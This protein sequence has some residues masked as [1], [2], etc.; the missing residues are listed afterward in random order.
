MIYLLKEIWT[1]G[2]YNIAIQNIDE[3]VFKNYTYTKLFLEKYTKSTLYHKS[4][5]I[6]D[7]ECSNTNVIIQV[8]LFFFNK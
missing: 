5:I 8:V 4:G 3:N 2:Y 6:L 1:Y 7:M